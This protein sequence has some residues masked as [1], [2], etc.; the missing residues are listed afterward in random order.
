[1]A[2]AGDARSPL[3]AYNVRWVNE[4]FDVHER[5]LDIYDIEGSKT[6][7]AKARE[8]QRAALIGILNAPV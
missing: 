8:L 5:L 1:M 3:G 4:S 7:L 6:A 2:L